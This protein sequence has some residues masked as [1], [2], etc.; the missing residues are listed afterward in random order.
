MAFLA[1]FFGIQLTNRASCLYI[2]IMEERIVYWV[3]QR[4]GGGDWE[5]TGKYRQP[6]Q[7]LFMCV[8]GQG[9]LRF[10][11]EEMRFGSRDFFAGQMMDLPMIEPDVVKAFR[12]QWV[13]YHAPDYPV[14][15]QR[16][17]VVDLDLLDTLFARLK[18]SF[19]N[20][21][22]R[23]REAASWLGALLQCVAE[24]NPAGDDDVSLNLEVV[25]PICQAIDSE[26]QRA[27]TV[28]DLARQACYSGSHFNRIFKEL[29]GKSPRA[30]ITDARLRYARTLLRESS[31]SVGN[32]AAE[33]G[34]SDIYHFSRQFRSHLGL[35]PT[36]YRRNPEALND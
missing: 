30:Y 23:S 15:P 22:G 24:D 12:F 5:W 33:L 2:S 16:P 29:T 14:F 1:E 32:I 25:R 8:A 17:K 36:Q 4:N 28:R 13:A 31:A 34:Y 27:W 11:G 26:P 3:E 35:S 21:G 19:R 6:H 9:K 18:R 20:F 7:M 10:N